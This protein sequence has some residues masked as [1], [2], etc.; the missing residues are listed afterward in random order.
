MLT[1]FTPVKII[2]EFLIQWGTHECVKHSPNAFTPTGN[3][4]LHTTLTKCEIYI[5][6]LQQ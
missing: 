1:Q 4:G 2:I 3:N 6:N 5:P